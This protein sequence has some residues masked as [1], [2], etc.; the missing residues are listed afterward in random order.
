MKADRSEW[1]ICDIRGWLTRKEAIALERH[2]RDK[3]VFEIGSYCGLSTIIMAK[4]AQRVYA[5]DWHKG[6]AGA[7]YGDTAAEF[8]NNLNKYSVRD[9]VISIVGNADDASRMIGRGWA[10]VVFVDGAH[11]FASVTRDL[12]LALWCLRMNGVI[13][14][15]DFDELS[16]ASAAKAS[17]GED[18][19]LRGELVDSL[20]SVTMGG[21]NAS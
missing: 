12:R 21:K 14:M 9:R 5:L 7:G 11:D 19:I 15:H 2:A 3:I 1:L 20:F 4:V 13:V 16:V 18:T 10:D 6:D 17:L 8:I